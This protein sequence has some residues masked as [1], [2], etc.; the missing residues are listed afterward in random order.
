[1]HTPYRMC[2]ACRKMKPKCE[3]IK[4]V[5]TEYGAALDKDQKKF[6]RGAYICKDKVCI[7]NAKKRRAFARHFKMA[8]DEK[9][10]DEI[11]EETENE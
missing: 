8:V 11:L 9:I 6:G 1:M 3:L 7:E 4:V 10:F 5:K 2:V